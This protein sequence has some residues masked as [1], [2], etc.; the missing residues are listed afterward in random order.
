MK[1]LTL[2]LA[3]GEGTRLH[4]LTAE[5]SKPALPFANGYRIVDFV[6]SNLVN[7]GLTSIYVV[8]QYKPQS[9]IGHIESAWGHRIG[10]RKG[11]VR[12]VLPRPEIGPEGFR[13]TA[14]AVYRNLDL[15]ERHRPDLVAVFAA[16]HVYRMDVGQMV[17]FHQARNADVTVAAVPVPVGIAGSFG[18]IV[19]GADGKLRAFQ[20]KPAKPVTIPGDSSRAYA[21][22]GNYL[23][24]TNVLVGLLHGAQR[25]GGTDFG[26]DILPRLPGRSRIYAYDFGNNY[27]PGVK[28]H[29]EPGYW[30]DVGTLA[31]LSAA[32]ADIVGSEPRFDLANLQWP[33][34]GAGYPSAPV[35][36]W[37][38]HSGRT[39]AALLRRIDPQGDEHRIAAG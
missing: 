23:F 17:C 35:R 28:T 39:H 6:L 9:L 34:H 19:T 33:I 24:D 29:E 11:F 15:I 4:P 14:D 32:Q 37:T 27:V 2:V 12:A 10:R 36:D 8:A 38:V 5:H 30:R 21:S 26:R 31:A 3:G 7:S 18:I 16:D 1:V 22:M 25:T 13:G 20:E